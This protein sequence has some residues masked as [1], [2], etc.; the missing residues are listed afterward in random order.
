MNIKK[1]LENKHYYER[2]ELEKIAERLAEETYKNDFALK[3]K[4]E[5]ELALFLLS[6]N[7]IDVDGNRL[8][9]AT[10]N[11]WWDKKGYWV[12]GYCYCP[13]EIETFVGDCCIELPEEIIE[14]LAKLNSKFLVKMGFGQHS[15]PSRFHWGGDGDIFYLTDIKIDD[16]ENIIKRLWEEYKEENDI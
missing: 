1:I 15:M 5:L 11:Y 13:S 8:S 4:E 12:C 16:G 10:Q 3:D 2:E 14:N 6:E 7:E 9:S